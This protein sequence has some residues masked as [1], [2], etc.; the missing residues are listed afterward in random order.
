MH[1]IT[2][3][4]CIITDIT[5]IARF[6][7]S[8]LKRT[9]LTYRLQPTRL[10]AIHSFFVDSLAYSTRLLQSQRANWIVCRMMKAKAWLSV[11]YVMCVCTQQG[12]N[13]TSNSPTQH[14]R[15]PYVLAPCFRDDI[16]MLFSVPSSS[17]TARRASRAP[18]P[19]WDCWAC[20]RR[21]E[22]AAKSSH[23]FEPAYQSNYQCFSSEKLRSTGPGEHSTH[24]VKATTRLHSFLFFVDQ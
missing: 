9:E 3:Y 7:R 1:A 23:T 6:I 14:E 4:P 16:E 8:P 10:Y 2:N 17:N 15:T 22:H 20:R 12:S 19:W 13:C 5:N 21:H 24:A 18:R 11:R